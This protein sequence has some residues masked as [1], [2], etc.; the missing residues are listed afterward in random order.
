MCAPGA[1]AHLL[2]RTEALLAK[3]ATEPTAARDA[4]MRATRAKNPFLSSTRH[5]LRTPLNSILGFTQLLRLS[6][7][8]DGVER[9]LGAGRHLL[10]LIDELTDIARIDSD[11][12]SLSLE[13]VSVRPLIQDSTQL[14]AP[15]A[16]ER[17]IRI[18]QNC[19]HPALAVFADRV[20]RPRCPGYPAMSVTRICPPM[21]PCPCGASWPMAT[22]SPSRAA[23]C[24]AS[25]IARAES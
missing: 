21:I 7:L 19:V 2:L 1:S 20:C 22:S 4:A 8:S 6:E 5:E 17:S 10:A 15:V 23:L 3:R 24:M 13:P 12:L 11:D 16:A 9:I 18:I 14:M 25:R